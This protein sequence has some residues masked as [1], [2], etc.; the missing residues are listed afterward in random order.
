MTKRRHQSSSRDVEQSL[1]MIWLDP[2]PGSAIR[3]QSE[4]RGLP[5]D[6][7]AGLRVKKSNQFLRKTIQRIALVVQMR[8][9]RAMR[10]RLAGDSLNQLTGAELLAARV[11]VLSQPVE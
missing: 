8:E 4:F 7:R 10:E 11:D 1:G 2:W 6:S 3:G 9:Q 5:A